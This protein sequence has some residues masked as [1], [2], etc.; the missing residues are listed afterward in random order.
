V[1]TYNVHCHDGQ[2]YTLIGEKRLEKETIINASGTSAYA[3]K[4]LFIKTRNIEKKYAVVIDLPMTPDR[5]SGLEPTACHV[6]MEGDKLSMLAA[7]DSL[8]LMQ[9]VELPRGDGDILSYES[10]EVVYVNLLISIRETVTAFMH[11][12][13][14]YDI[15]K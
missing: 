3:I 15:Y 14:R 5:P 1:E 9:H 12:A 4:F 13:A 8:D 7:L 6:L 2:T 10:R 11:E